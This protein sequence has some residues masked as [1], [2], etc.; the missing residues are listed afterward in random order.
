MKV[1]NSI[2]LTPDSDL[3][4]FL[5]KTFN[6]DEVELTDGNNFLDLLHP[7]EFGLLLVGKDTRADVR[8]KL[9]ITRRSGLLRQP[10]VYVCLQS[11][12]TI[13]NGLVSFIDEV[14]YAK[15]A[16]DFNRQR[17]L[18]RFENNQTVVRS[19]LRLTPIE[20]RLFELLFGKTPPLD[21]R[22]LSQ[23]LGLARKETLAVHITNLNKKLLAQKIRP[24][25]RVSC[26]VEL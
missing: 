13:D 17:L 9:M 2:P 26:E 5:F 19:F 1:F 20:S 7:T 24:R 21:R 22:V 15:D 14:I 4:H 6:H 18:L 16:P 10:V 8:L 23:E 3:E 11:C 25:S 12:E